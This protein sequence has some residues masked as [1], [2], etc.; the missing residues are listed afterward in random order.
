MDEEGDFFDKKDVNLTEIFRKSEP[1]LEELEKCSGDVGEQ[2]RRAEKLRDETIRKYK[3][4]K[5]P[6]CKGTIEV[7]GEYI[8]NITEIEKH[9]E[10]IVRDVEEA[11]G[12]EDICF[13]LHLFKVKHDC[14]H[15]DLKKNA[16]AVNP[17]LKYGTLD[18]AVEL[19]VPHKR[20]WGQL[21]EYRMSM[22]PS[23]FLHLLLDD[24]C[25]NYF[26]P[27]LKQHE[28]QVRCMNGMY[29]ESL[30]QYGADDS[31][32]HINLFVEW[33]S[34]GRDRGIFYSDILD[35][36]KNT[37]LRKGVRTELK[38]SPLQILRPITVEYDRWELIPLIIPVTL[39]EK[40]P[41]LIETIKDILEKRLEGC[42]EVVE[43][44]KL[45]YTHKIANLSYSRGETQR[46]IIT[47][48]KIGGCDIE[49][50]NMLQNDILFGVDIEINCGL[51]SVSSGTVKPPELDQKMKGRFDTLQGSNITDTD[52]LHGEVIPFDNDLKLA[53]SQK[54]SAWKKRNIKT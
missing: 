52:P 1:I 41:D 16:V 14:F 40:Y 25:D 30:S 17:C 11:H 54:F 19:S 47:A 8:K 50:I 5:N 42:G 22:S 37:E 9:F 32:P 26:F 24:F 46:H 45:D 15:T 7:I 29:P 38:N 23:D 18:S 3:V 4:T 13:A 48:R 39:E 21:R 35:L 2:R 12:S 49:T 44:P 28:E 43:G 31:P 33:S 36:K 6:E 10:E 34:A 27:I 20:S 51:E 53:Y